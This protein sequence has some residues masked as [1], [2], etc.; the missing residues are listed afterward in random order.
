MRALVQRVKEGSVKI[1]SEN[2]EQ[3]IGQGLVVL[4]GVKDG[5]R[6]EEVN[7]VADKCCNLRI[8]SDKA[9]KMNLNIK[10]IDGEA[11]VISQF[12][13]AG[14]VKKGRRPSFDKAMASKDAKELY[15]MFCKELNKEIPVKT[16]IFGAMMEIEII[17]DGPVTFVV[18]SKELNG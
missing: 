10:D 17:N 13:L 16:G 12:T 14:S 15:E 7:F 18:D 11:L 8:F 6:I 4:L 1:I 5:D 9:Q 2:Y 3:N